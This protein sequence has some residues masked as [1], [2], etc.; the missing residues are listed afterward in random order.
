MIWPFRHKSSLPEARLWNHLDACA[1]PFRAPLGDWVAQMHLTASGWSDGL[2]Y[3]IPDTQTPLFAGL[4]VPV[5]AQISEYTNFDAPP[6]YLW[7]AVQGAKD[8]RLNYAK[9]LAGL[10]KVF[11]KGTA[12][13][14]SNTVSRNWSFGLA[15][16]SCTVW[17]PNKNRHGTNSR[18]QMFPETI[19]EAS[20]AI[21]PAWRPPL[22]EAE[23]AACATATNF[24]IDPEPHQ[25][26]NLT[27]R[28]RDWPTTLPQLPQGLSMTPRGDL[29]VTCP[30]GIVDI[31]KA[32]RVKALKLDRLTPARGGA[33]AHLNAVTTVTARDGPIDKPRGIATLGA[34]SDGLDA[35][36]QDLA[37]KL[38]VPLDIW[39]GAND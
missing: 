31:Y 34:R 7:G 5:R 16:V 27:S 38:G 20:I 25:R 21:Y 15:R 2:D 36:A 14:A 18:H 13:S 11:G 3:C 17:P 10:T 23:F 19:E 30:L 35:V 9:A 6:D 8:H 28:S 39:T 24:W 32:G 26:A 1:I 4:D 12:S 22:E 29:L 37:A 33:C